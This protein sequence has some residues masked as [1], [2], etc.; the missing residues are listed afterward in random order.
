M[1]Q[2]KELNGLPLPLEVAEAKRGWGSFLTFDLALPLKLGSTETKPGYTLWIYL[3][4]WEIYEND[5]LVLDCDETDDQVYRKA[6]HQFLGSKLLYI[7]ID[8]DELT[9]KF[10]FEH[11]KILSLE[12]DL[13]SYEEGDDIFMVFDHTSGM[14]TSMSPKR[15]VYSELSSKKPKCR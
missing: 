1:K 8:L 5:R 9:A 3:S 15:G 7:R 12:P 10:F 4:D 11:D 13:E 14:V 6:L 2:I